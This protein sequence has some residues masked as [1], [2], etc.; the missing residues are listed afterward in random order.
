MNAR[1]TLPQLT[2]VLYV[3]ILSAALDLVPA[4]TPK[5]VV[6]LFNIFPALLTKVLWPLI[7]SG[8]IQY[9]RRVLFCTA[10]SWLGIVVSW[11][12]IV[13]LL[14]G[15][16]L[17]QVCG[18]AVAAQ[19][20]YPD[21]TSFP[22]IRLLSC[23]SSPSPFARSLYHSGLLVLDSHFTRTPLDRAEPQTIALSSGLPARLFGISL[24]SLSSG[25]GELTFL[26]LTTTLPTRSTS[27]TALGAWSSGTG[28]AGIAGAGLWWLLRGLGVKAGLGISSVS[29]CFF[30]KRFAFC[31]LCS[32]C[33]Q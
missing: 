18:T 6:A 14:S 29:L 3:I 31:L 26:Q 7:S 12:R 9:K 1:T 19:L 16:P 5:G 28:A 10:C 17:L 27:R 2:P 22:A 13:F 15:K 23:L 11:L 32:W 20:C 4:S 33:G 8:E 25:L 24:A 21:D 30:L